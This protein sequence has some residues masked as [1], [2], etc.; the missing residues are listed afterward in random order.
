[1]GIAHRMAATALA[2][3]LA[4]VS[5]CGTPGA[6][7]P[8]SLHLPDRVADLTAVRAGDEVSLAWTM[9]TKDTDKLLQQE[10]MEAAICRQVEG[11]ACEAVKTEAALK[12]GAA[13]T[14]TD[15]LPP[16]LTSGQPRA[17]R[18]FVELKNRNGR[19]AGLSN[20]GLTLAGESPAP[21]T[22]LRAEVHKRGMVLL[23]T[24]GATGAVRL[25]RT[26]LTPLKEKP[27]EGLLVPPPEPVEQNLLVE[28][29]AQKGRAIDEDIRWGETYEYRAQRV[30][31]ATVDR[32]VLE[33]D[34]AY[35]EPVRVEAKDVF[36]PAVPAGLAAVATVP[37]NGAQAAIDLS[38][39]PGTEDDLA[40]YVVYRRE[41]GEAWERISPAGPVAGPAFH[42]DRVQPGHTYHYAVSAV[43][44]DGH[45]STRSAE[46]QETVP[47]R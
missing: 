3:G 44:Q 18:Y 43:S 39:E 29:G 2:V 32:E 25:R 47:G 5:G 16:E 1:M 28:T 22:G 7:L 10:N 30:I 36:P 9:P 17:L 12:P 11:G 14:Y 15:K 38:W 37:E 6:P 45:E 4:G 34:S 19:S 23:W 21:V 42:D 31:R 13:C 27:K 46:A 20:V 40:G 35:S 33:L 41:D 8:P 24:P 26:L